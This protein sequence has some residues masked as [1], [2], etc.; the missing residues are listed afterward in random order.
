METCPTGLGTLSTICPICEHSPLA[1]EDC[2]PN[3]S[4]RT[5]V[6]VFLKTAEKK[7]ALAM[8]QQKKAGASAAPTPEPAAVKAPEVQTPQT[9]AAETPTVGKEATP[10]AATASVQDGKEDAEK[11]GWCPGYSTATNICQASNQSQPAEQ[12]AK[13]QHGSP[14]GTKANATPQAQQQ[15]PQQQQM[16]FSN[17]QQQNGWFANPMGAMGQMFPGQD[18]SAWGGYNPMM[19]GWGDQF[20]GMMGEQS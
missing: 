20:G 13:S 1:K 11:V 18:F 8:S 16:G 14:A 19:G 7:H 3:Q 17:M 2:K 5:T 10:D 12:T 6:A 9:P 15:P 4:L